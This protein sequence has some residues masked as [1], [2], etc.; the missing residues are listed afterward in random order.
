MEGGAA[1]GAAGSDTIS[2]GDGDDSITGNGS[3]DVLQ[4]NQGNDFLTGA[5]SEINEAFVLSPALLDILNNVC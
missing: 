2:G 5:P 1:V 4:G 3:L